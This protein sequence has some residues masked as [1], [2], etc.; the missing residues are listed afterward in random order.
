M[1]PC[2]A[3]GNT[4]FISIHRWLSRS[5]VEMATGPRNGFR[6]NNV[7]HFEGTG[8]EEYNLYKLSNLH[9]TNFSITFFSPNIKQVPSADADYPSVGERRW[10]H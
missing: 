8:R 7:G 3:A 2:L 1:I 4:F 10:Q 9:M 5:S 6:K